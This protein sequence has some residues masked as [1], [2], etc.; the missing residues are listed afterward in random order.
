MNIKRPLKHHFHHRMRYQFPVQ[1]IELRSR[2]GDDGAGQAELVC[3]ATGAHFHTVGVKIRC[4]AQHN[5]HHRLGESILR[6]SHD[7]DGEFGRKF[8][9]RGVFAGQRC[10]GHDVLFVYYAVTRSGR[11]RLYS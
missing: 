6:L 1:G 4:V 5:F 8:E 10:I 9:R 2:L 7:L 3:L 11:V